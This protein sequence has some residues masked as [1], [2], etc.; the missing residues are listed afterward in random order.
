MQN[1]KTER[2][3]PKRCSACRTQ[4][5]Q[6]RQ[7]LVEAE[8]H[9]EDAARAQEKWE[10]D[11]RK[12]STLLS[13]LPFAQAK[14][15]DLEIVNPQTTLVIIGNGFDIMHGVKSSYN[16]FQKTIGKNSPLRWAIETYLKCDDLWYNFEESLA[17]LDAGAMLDMTDMWLDNFN[18]YDLNAQAAD[19]FAAIDTAMG[20]IQ[21]LLNDFPR[22]FRAWVETLTCD[23]TKPMEHL[24][25]QNA[26]YLNFNYTD[27][28][29][30]LYNVLHDRIK[31]IHGCRKK[32]KGKPKKK[33]ILGH[34]PD[35]DYLKAYK[36]NRQLIPHYKSERK[37]YLLES[38]MDTGVDRWVNN[39]E[40][41]FTKNTS[42]IIK[43]NTEFFDKTAGVEDIYVIGHSLSE[44]DYPYFVEIAK[45]NEGKAKWHIGYH[46]LAD[47][48]RLI[49]LVELLQVKNI[50]VFRI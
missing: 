50:E 16:D 26:L 24:V 39:Y 12:L 40:N 23:G 20:P 44:V 41:E 45:R 38:V 8:L 31:Y 36:P 35:V 48:K 10:R 46:S 2:S 18:A 27:L 37:A 42:Y 43:E 15:S 1:K 19:N 29:E 7:V 14:L 34:V 4:K 28:L 3:L 30:W 32:E 25:K 22:R 5:Q 11:E 13:T 6:E 17:H 47:M 49:A 9:K 21:T 33:L